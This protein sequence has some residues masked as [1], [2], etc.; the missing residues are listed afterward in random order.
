MLETDKENPRPPRIRAW[1]AVSVCAC[2]IG[3]AVW[4]TDS[5]MP[6]WAFSFLPLIGDSA[7]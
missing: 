5:A 6:L 2:V 4:I 3:L 1:V 7:E